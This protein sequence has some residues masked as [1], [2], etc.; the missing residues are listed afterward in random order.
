MPRSW[1]DG[2][3]FFVFLLWFEFIVIVIILKPRTKTQTIV[4]HIGP[5]RDVTGEHHE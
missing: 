5:N 4:V 2:L 3:P 1:I